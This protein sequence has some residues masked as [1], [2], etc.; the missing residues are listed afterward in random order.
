MKQLTFIEMIELKGR[1]GGRRSWKFKIGLWFAKRIMT[2][3]ANDP[4]LRKEL[5]VILRIAN[6]NE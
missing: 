3:L 6:R 1:N 4:Q 5:A 2:A